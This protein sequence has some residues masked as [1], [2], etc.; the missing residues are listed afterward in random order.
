MVGQEARENCLTRQDMLDFFKLVI[1]FGWQD[2]PFVSGF[3]S[4]FV[5]HG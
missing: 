5:S 1:S 2:D 4:F 3:Y